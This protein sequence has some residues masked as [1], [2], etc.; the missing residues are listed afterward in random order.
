MREPKRAPLF[1]LATLAA[2]HVPRA[3]D[4]V[5]RE[6]A[7][8]ARAHRDMSALFGARTAGWCVENRLSEPEFGCKER[9]RRKAR[10]LVN[11]GASLIRVAVF[12]RDW[13]QRLIRGLLD[14]IRWEQERSIR[15]RHGGTARIHPVDVPGVAIRLI[16]KQSRWIDDV[17]TGG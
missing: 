14:R 1:F 9:Q 2:K 16:Y 5:D 13:M 17:R 15:K 4:G 7:N 3:R 12:D 10:V 8:D 11:L 6:E